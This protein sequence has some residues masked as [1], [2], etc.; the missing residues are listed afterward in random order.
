MPRDKK[1]KKRRNVNNELFKKLFYFHSKNLNKPLVMFW[2]NLQIST[3]EPKFDERLCVM[4]LLG[5][6]APLPP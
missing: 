2:N 6:P 1:I 4:S 5:P 3:L